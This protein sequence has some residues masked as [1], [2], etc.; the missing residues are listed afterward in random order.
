ME[1][2]LAD[3]QQTYFL[4]GDIITDYTIGRAALTTASS[5]YDSVCR[6][7]RQPDA[8]EISRAQESL[9]IV[10]QRI[11][12][13]EQQIPEQLVTVYATVTPG[14]ADAQ[15]QVTE[16]V[17]AVVEAT[18]TEQPGLANTQQR[19]YIQQLISIISEV[20]GNDGANTILTS[21]WRDVQQTGRTGG[22]GQPRPM[23]PP[24]D[25]VPQ[26][27]IE[28]N[29]PELQTAWS[30]LRD[31]LDLLRSGWQ[32]FEDACANNSLQAQLNIGQSTVETATTLISNANQALLSLR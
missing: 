3:D 10:Q 22:C 28:A 4:I 7:A 9:G 18:A 31:G 11:A 8:T 17:T 20:N 30:Q 25:P 2:R 29:E 15:P 6:E 27:I 12:A 13:I 5:T 1:V 21:Y 19:A 14:P 16:E 32:L 24:L 23:I 26:D